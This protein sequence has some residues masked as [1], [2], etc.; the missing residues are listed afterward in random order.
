MMITLSM[1]NTRSVTSLVAVA[2]LALGMTSP[3]AA[4]H[5]HVHGTARLYL[6]VD[7]QRV[8]FRLESPLENLLGFERAP[9]TEK[10]TA[11]VKSMAERLARPDALFAL[12]AAAR[13]TAGT[14]RI[15][16]PVV[17][18]AGHSVAAADAQAVA[19]GKSG[20][21]GAKKGAKADH[22]DLEAQ[23]VF[24]CEDIARLHDVEVR[25]FDA[26]RGLRQLDV[27]AVTPLGQKSLRLTPSKRQVTW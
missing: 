16:A 25:L 22:A 27:Q 8:N 2:A 13:C 6:A 10:E 7:Q 12:T 14:V 3:V 18:L 11:A 19:P 23:F 20:S 26:F 21:G 15:H 24:Q 4:Q 1:Q 9:R 17:G 5:A